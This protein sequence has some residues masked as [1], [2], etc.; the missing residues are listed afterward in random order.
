MKKGQKVL[1]ILVIFVCFGFIINISQKEIFAM[2]SQTSVIIN[3]DNLAL[4]KTTGDIEVTEEHFPDSAFRNYLI[5]QYGNT[6]TQ[7]Q[8]AMIDRLYIYG[9]GIQSLEGIE[10]FT[11]LTVLDCSNNNLTSLDVSHNAELEVLNCS[12]NGI[13][14]LNLTNNIKL[15][16]VT[17]YEGYS[18]SFIDISKCP[19]L[20]KLRCYGN[21]LP[22]L[23]ISNNTKLISLECFDNKITSLD[24][25]K[26]VDLEELLCTDNQISSLNLS[27]NSKLN[28]LEC[29]NNYLTYLNVNGCDDLG[30]IYGS[31]NRLTSL[32]LSQNMN[33][34][35]YDAELSNQSRT[36]TVSTDTYDLKNIDPNID[37]TKIKN[38][39][40]ATLTGTIIKD[41]VNGTPVKYNYNC[42]NGIVMPVTLNLKQQITN[43]WV[44]FLSI[45]NWKYGQIAN[46]P[47]AVAK[48][49][50]PEFSYSDMID[51]NYSKTV[52]NEAGT[53][54]VKATV[55]A[56]STYAK[57]ESAPVEFKIEKAINEWIT[58]LDI[59]D[60]TYLEEANLP[61]AEVR[62][63]NDQLTYQYSDQEDGNYSNLVPNEAGIWYV[64][65]NVVGTSN[66]KELS[67]VKRFEIKKAVPSYTLPINLTGT[68]G[69]Q[70][71]DV[72]LPSG[73]EWM[74]DTIILGNKG[75]Q[76]Y[77]AKYIPTDFKNYQVV[78][79]IEIVVN[80][81][82]ESVTVPEIT[83]GSEAI[84]QIG[85]G[86][87][88]IV[89][90][91]GAL[92]DLRGIYVDEQ[93]VEETHYI[94]KSGSTILTLKSEYLDTLVPGWHT[95]RFAYENKSAETKFKIIEKTVEPAPQPPI[96]KPTVENSSTDS[97]LVPEKNETFGEQ[98]ST[99]DYLDMKLYSTLIL[100]SGLLAL[101]LKYKVKKEGTS[102]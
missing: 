38:L 91:S 80:I 100:L 84:Y 22:A 18:L 93:L 76:T 23:D 61:N 14:T 13:T 78:E 54:Y 92:E 68:A 47:Q 33:L 62:Y 52:P 10:Y 46:Q 58:A 97:T 5:N 72:I 98:P 25:S 37:E 32:D 2:D 39:A 31:F 42:G 20:E 27:H 6:I 26:N 77:K 17:C 16:E 19:N 59:K 51:G 65:A 83:I 63:G 73:F 88:I 50:I 94:L 60:W 57:L 45:D 66:Y 79:N 87:D 30:T 29:E 86:D 82:D 53:Y 75:L 7:S 81:V 34:S 99:A 21:I 9:K 24:T 41:Y 12:K 95:L 70:L 69:K 28:Y 74:D 96:D 43:E 15:T 3:M 11:A 40:G 4:P 35:V 85:S 89:V 48:Y 64:K 67:S 36:F 8:I 44:E 102:F 101:A 90:C 56:T 1:I 55:E 71:S 49:G